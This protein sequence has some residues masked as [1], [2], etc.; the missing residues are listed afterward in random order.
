MWIT[1]VFLAFIMFLVL[2]SVCKEQFVSQWG[3]GEVLWNSSKG[4]P[5]KMATMGKYV[6]LPSPT[7]YNK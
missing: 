5:F 6:V 3:S 7:I 4:P 2:I 1:N